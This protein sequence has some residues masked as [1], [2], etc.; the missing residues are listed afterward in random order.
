MAQE[1]KLGIKGSINLKSYKKST[2][3]SIFMIFVGLLIISPIMANYQYHYHQGGH[4][5]HH[6]HGHQ[7]RDPNKHK[8]KPEY[9]SVLDIPKGSSLAKVKSAFKKIAIKYH[10]DRAPDG[11]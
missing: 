5:H 9:Y 11:Q 3:L 8:D 4:G 2:K 1:C 7:H 6:G 10:P